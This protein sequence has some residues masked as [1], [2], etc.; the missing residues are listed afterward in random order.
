MRGTINF[1]ALLA[2]A[3]TAWVGLAVIIAGIGWALA[4]WPEAASL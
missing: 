4:H 1:L 2:L 3:V